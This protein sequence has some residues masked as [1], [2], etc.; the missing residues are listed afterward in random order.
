MN[1]L[2]TGGVGYL[3]CWV[4]NELLRRKHR[5]RIFDRMCFGM[6]DK[7]VWLKESGVEII[8]GDIR[9]WQK[10]PDL[11]EGID[12]VIHLAGLAND[13]SCAL[14]PI[15]A[16]EVNVD[17]TVEL[18]RQSS[19]KGVKKFI[20]ASTCA[21]YGKG[22]GDWLDES[23]P[24]NPLSI[25]TQTKKEAE[26]LLRDMAYDNFSPVIARFSTLFGYSPRM[27]FDLAINQ[28]VSMAKLQGKIEVR[29]G[30]N[31]WRPFL[32]VQDCAHAVCLLCE[33]EQG[34]V[35]NKIFNIGDNQFNKKI[36]DLA[37][38]IAS[39]I[40]GTY[41]DVVHD[42]EDLR[43]FRV[44]FNKFSS[45][46]NF[47]PQYT[48]QNGV[49]E[50]LNWIEE[51]PGENPFS[52]KYI[53]AFRFKQLKNIPVQKGG[54]PTAPYFIPL[55]R[56]TLGEEEEQAVLQAMRSG[57][58]TSGHKIHAFEQDFALAVGAKEAVAVSSC[59]SAIHLCLVEAGLKPGDEVITPP[60]TWVS[61]INT[62]LHSGIKPVFVDVDP[63]T[64]NINPQL[65]EGKITERTKAIIP[66]DLGGHPC[67]LD[68]I[69]KIAEKYH[70]SLIEDA[71][72][73]LGALYRSQ[74]IGSI[75]ERTCFSFYATKNITTIEG[76]MITLSDPDKAKYLRILATNGLTDTAWDRYGRSA[77]YRPQELITAGFKYG[78]SNVSAS[79]GVEQLKK[80]T[81]FNNNRLRLATRYSCLLSEI[82]EIILPTVKDYVQPAWHL[83]IIRIDTKKVKKT[84]DEIAFMLRQEN[85]GTGVHFYGIHL[86]PYIQQLCGVK[87]E[88]CPVATQI[89][90]EILSLPLYPTLTE[91]NIQY[92]VD[93]IK[94]VIYYAKH[95]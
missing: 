87:P 73:A 59:T 55:S 58:L 43:T 19:Q 8:E 65:I 9:H 92:T 77:T 76:G 95:S 89:S 36:I 47:R 15:T 53:N 20:F 13:P 81:A 84:R 18:A 91:E 75:A 71:A 7:A 38:E 11:F 93:A 6:P 4:A 12:V 31:Q 56:P 5:I 49:Q 37:N 68:E 79:I 30:G 70:L 44:Q 26:D 48:I 25:F 3:G 45:Q 40:D 86:Q 1:V 63:I 57:W 27:R 46:F 62:L 72:H 85:I 24:T 41:I 34:L 90:N 67:E 35:H 52:D 23:S 83:Y 50:V 94:K 69:K 39:Y 2:I 14:S 29:G 66:V 82:D 42:D 16:K 22:I 74:R 28:M 32:H 78:M 51:H 64:F 54:E 17:C 33:A 88:D 60:I 10:F 80:L 21:V 61:T